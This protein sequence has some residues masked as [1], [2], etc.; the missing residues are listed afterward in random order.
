MSVI[1]YLVAEDTGDGWAVFRNACQVAHRGDLF[2]AVAFATHM[3][4]REA[5]RT[6]CRVRVTTSMDSLEAVKGSGP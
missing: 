1:D 3:A 2:D 5:T 4:E 6:P